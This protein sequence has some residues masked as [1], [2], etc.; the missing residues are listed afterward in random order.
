MSTQNTSAEYIAGLPT[1]PCTCAN[2]RRAA[3]AVTRL[4]NHELR[5]QQIEITQFTILMALA[6]AGEITQGKLGK[7]LALDST[8]LTRMLELLRNRGWIQE[9]EGE[10]R[11]FRIIR[12]TNAGRAKLQHS[13]PHWKRAQN[14][15]QNVLGEGTM[16][17]LAVLLAKVTAT[18]AGG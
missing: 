8:T 9:K 10:D 4:Y 18:S 15:L 13:V 17:Q 16:G 7:V 12:L 14:R 1:L 6:R 3:R 2:L 5:P 11:R